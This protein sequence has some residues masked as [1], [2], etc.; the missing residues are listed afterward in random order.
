[1]KKEGIITLLFTI[2]VL[3]LSFSNPQDDRTR[4]FPKTELKASQLPAKED[5]WVF[6]LAGQSNMAGRG[7][8]EPQD[9]IPDRR[10]FTINKNGD[11][12]IAKEPL[13]FYEPTLTGLDCGLSFA[14]ALIRQIPDSISVLLI[15]CAVGG[16]SVSQ[17]SG[18]ITYREVKLLTNFKEKAGIGMR[19]GQIKGILWHQGESDT[20]PVDMPLY[21]SRISQLFGEFRR[22]T[23]NNQLPVLIGELGSYSENNELWQGINGQIRAYISSDPYSRIIYTSDLKE[24]GDRIHFNSEGQRI[25]GERFASEFIKSFYLVH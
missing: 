2:L 24:K 10:I 1:M 6:I 22:I 8:V 16:S 3:F 25:M 12:I 15:P 11:I 21:K 13:H 17:W 20:N 23:G 5:L 19:Y 14:K 7:L 4:F 18:D 9:T